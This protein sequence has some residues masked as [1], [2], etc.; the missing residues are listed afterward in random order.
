MKGRKSSFSRHW[1]LWVLTG[2]ALLSSVGI[3]ALAGYLM[4][5]QT[6]P[7]R[8]IQIKNEFRNLDKV[9][10]QQALLKAIDGGFFSV[11]LNR[12]RDAALSAALSLIHI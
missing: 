6:L 11:D 7:I 9:S 5:T 8:N 12:L 10:L 4:N 2:F 1:R 3:Y